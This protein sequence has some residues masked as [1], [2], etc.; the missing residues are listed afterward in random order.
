MIRG[1]GAA[2]VGVVRIGV[3]LVATAGATGVVTGDEFDAP[4]VDAVLDA[5]LDE[6]FGDKTADDRAGLKDSHLS[7]VAGWPLVKPLRPA[8]NQAADTAWRWRAEGEAAVPLGPEP[9]ATRVAVPVAGDYR[10][11]LRQAVLRDR[12]RP[13]TMTLT[14]GAK[15]V[16]AT[17]VFGDFALRASEPAGQE[18]KRLPIRFE[19]EAQRVAFPAAETVLW[20]HWDVK[21]DAGEYE[22]ALAV[23]G[24]DARVSALFLSRSRSFRPSLASNAADATLGRLFV[25]Y[26][27]LDQQP[28]GRPADIHASLVYHWR[29]L[30]PNGDDLWGW[31]GGGAKSVPAGQWSPFI[32]VTEAVVPGPGPW[33]TW[34]VGAAGVTRGRLEAQ[35]AWTPH[36]AAGMFSLTTAIGSDGALFRYP[37]GSSRDDAAGPQPTWGVWSRDHFAPAMSQEAIIERYYAWT[38]EARQRLGLPADHPTTRAIRLYANC[39]VPAAHRER[40]S[41]MLATVG[42]NWIP[43]APEAVV[44]KHRLLEG[45]VLYNVGMARD[46]RQVGG[47]MSP[48]ERLRVKKIKIG[49]EIHTHT[50]AA[51]INEDPASLKK[52]HAYL[53]ERMEAEGGDPVSFLGVADLEELPCLGTLPENAGRFERRL[54]YHASRFSHLVTA[55]HYRD[56]TATLQARFPD[57]LIYNNYSPHPLFLTGS[58]M[59]EI[60][61]FVLCR[62]RAQSLGWGEDWA[63]E[64]GWSLGTAFQIVSFY[65]ALVECSVRRHGQPAGFYVGVNCGGAGQKIFSCVGRGLTWLELYAWGPIDGLA[66]GSNAWSED[67]DQYFAVMQAAHALGPADTILA[68]GRREPRRVAILYNRSHEICQQGAGRL[69]VDWMWTFLGLAAA[70]VPADVILEEDLD[71]E[72]LK[73][74]DVLLLGGFN[75]EGRHIAAI[76]DWVERGGL[77]VGSGGTARLDVSG[78]PL[79]ATEALF[80]A[81]QRPLRAAEAAA[82][83]TARF[84]DGQLWPE[85]VEVAPRGVLHLLEPVGAGRAVATYEGGGAA[86]VEQVLGKGRTL[87][88]GFHPGYTLR[89]S[90]GTRGPAREWLAAPVLSRLGRPRADVDHPSI[91]TTLFEHD[92]GIAVLL[93]AFGSV[94]EGERVV[95][96]A[97]DRDVLDVTSS[98]RG[99]LAWKRQGDRIEIRSP[100]IDRVDVIMIR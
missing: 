16:A 53:R 83:K 37:N 91:E 61:W 87:L 78:D 92:S 26:R 5:E 14:G 98:L 25:R 43:A 82:R 52:F 97:T 39:N 50:P 22:I 6:A 69:N 34:R 95:S 17:H 11:C 54:Y 90:G 4:D 31:D 12:R 94:P 80:G 20:E 28:A 93:S 40:A 73:P 30:G 35:F 1:R 15:A 45:D 55:D 2:C 7:F 66:E 47:G 21:L 10:I 32:D 51:T 63:Y 19:T 96:V 49:D 36:E 86:A 74:Y 81:R 44:E 56:K 3:A 67:Q 23:P 85:P 88:L 41:D 75:L 77:L 100:P 62:N 60:D 65:A 57:A 64:G 27:I 59:N 48:A 33:S 29:R 76:R 84:E 58:D 71:A 99:P 24:G 8:K 79:P 89:D 68:Q 46:L 72:H 18:E 70:H 9:I 13:V 38:D 42:A